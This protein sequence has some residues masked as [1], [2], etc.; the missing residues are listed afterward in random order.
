MINE[1]FI[2]KKDDKYIVYKKINNKY[3]IF[4][5]Y[6]SLFDAKVARDIFIADGWPIP[7]EDDA[8]VVEES[9]EYINL[10]FKVGTSYKHGFLVLTRSET[11]DLIPALPYE[12]EC[13]IIFDGI[14]A[15]IKLNVLLRLNITKGNSELRDYLKELSGIDPKQRANLQFILNKEDENPLNTTK[16]LKEKLELEEKLKKANEKIDELESK[17]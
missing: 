4:G 7:I 12:D 17:L 9:D 5:E 1:S 10:S 3:H 11:E 6:D 14:K 8:D 15:K 13:D 2:E 16:L